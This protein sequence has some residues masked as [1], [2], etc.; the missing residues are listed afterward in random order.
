[1]GRLSRLSSRE[2]SVDDEAT[3][4]VKR[5]ASPSDDQVD[6]SN[7]PGAATVKDENSASPSP[8]TVLTAVRTKNSRSSSTSTTS[9]KRALASDKDRSSAKK[10]PKEAN[11]HTSPVKLESEEPTKSTKQAKT[12]RSASSKL[13]PRIAPLLDHLPDVY[14]EATSTFAVIDACTYQNKYLGFSDHAL[15]CDCS[16][17]WGEFS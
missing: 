3:V 17:E 10:E 4:H 6:Y 8:I 2:A 11:G 16:E 12:S 15:D 5:E 14:A 13:P 9:S 1:M 7:A